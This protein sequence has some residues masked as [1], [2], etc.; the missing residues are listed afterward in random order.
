MNTLPRAVKFLLI[1]FAAI[2]CLF[3]VAMDR[4]PSALKAPFVVIF[5]KPA[6]IPGL[7]IDKLERALRKHPPVLGS[8]V[9]FNKTLVFPPKLRTTNVAADDITVAQVTS[10]AGGGETQGLYV[11]QRIGFQEAEDIAGFFEAL[12]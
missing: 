8:R 4:P 3:V 9:V 12:K 7:S 6:K 5:D 11:A 10:A 1:P 2:L